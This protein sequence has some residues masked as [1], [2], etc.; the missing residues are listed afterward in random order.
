MKDRVGNKLAVN[1]KVLVALPDATIFGFVAQLEEPG[2]I[3]VQRGTKAGTVQGRIFVT[4]VIALPVD[5]EA[6]AVPQLVKVYD[7]DKH[8]GPSL[9]S[10][11]PSPPSKAN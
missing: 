4:C 8:E 11:G 5:A 1:D 3:A 9:V 6:G 7:P 2:L 10:P